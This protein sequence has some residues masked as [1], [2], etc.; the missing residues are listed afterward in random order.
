MAFIHFF[1]LLTGL[2][3]I[4]VWI[5]SITFMRLKHKK[6]FPYLVFFTI[7]YMY[8]AKVFD[9]TLFQF[10]SLLIL[11][12]FMPNLMLQGQ[13]A[14]Q[15]INLIPLITLTSDDIQTSLLNILL[16][17]PFGFGLPFI[18]NFRMKKIVLIGMGTSISIESLQM[19]TGLIAETTF[20]IADI[21]DIIFNTVGVAIGYTLFLI[22][23]RMYRCL[24]DNWASSN[25]F[26]Q[27]IA[28]QIENHIH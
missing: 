20:R 25:P 26:I 4:L 15:S 18:T 2:F 19:M 11:K 17:I 16:F 10:Q 13:T 7:F 23:I 28:D 27:Y 12:Y 9:Y 21:N 14:D 3:V 24:P 22:F 5:G 1:N 8:I 6:S